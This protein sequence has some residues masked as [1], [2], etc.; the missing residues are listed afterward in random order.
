[1]Q[2]LPGKWT[3]STQWVDGKR[4]D[5]YIIVQELTHDLLSRCSNFRGVIDF[6]HL[7]V[8]VTL[9]TLKMCIGNGRGG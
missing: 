4:N 1:M 5:D 7:H 2:E 6:V 8:L 3:K 9:A